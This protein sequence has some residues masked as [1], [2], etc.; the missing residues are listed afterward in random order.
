MTNTSRRVVAYSGS[1]GATRVLQS[2]VA[3]GGAEVVTLTLD[4]GQCA[5]MGQ[6]RDAALAA[7]AVR[8][9]VIDVREEFARDHLLPALAAGVEEEGWLPL[10]RS[11]ARPLVAAKLR[12]IAGI[13]E[14]AIV[15]SA[16]AYDLEVSI[17]GRVVIDGG[18]RLTKSAAAAPASAAEVVVRFDGGVPV[19]IND[20]ALPL[21]ELIESLATIAGQ[22][23]VGRFAAVEVPAA[24][25]LQAALRARHNGTARLTLFRSTVADHRELVTR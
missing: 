6:V 24:V 3:R 16:D 9:H 12:E 4:L 21:T 20:V 25:L 8:A 11:L 19:A 15:E 18:Y 2:L 13:E 7:G 10:V 17:A 5:E 22:H 1:A 14:A 23:G